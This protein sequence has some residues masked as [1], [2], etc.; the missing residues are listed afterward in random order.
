MQLLMRLFSWAARLVA[1][2]IGLGLLLGAAFFGSTVPWSIGDALEVAAGLA[3]AA[4]LALPLFC[5]RA[6]LAWRLIVCIAVAYFALRLI[7][8]RSFAL[9]DGAGTAFA[10]LIAVVLSRAAAWNLPR[11]SSRASRD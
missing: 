7:D 1:F 2:T 11:K 8:T 3:G 5:G 4:C 6:Q 9:E 10:L